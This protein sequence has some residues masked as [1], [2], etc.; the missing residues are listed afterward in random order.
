[1]DAGPARHMQGIALGRRGQ[2]AITYVGRLR[3][4]HVVH[5]FVQALDLLRQWH[6]GKADGNVRTVQC[7]QRRQPRWSDASGQRAAQLPVTPL[8]RPSLYGAPAPVQRTHAAHVQ[9]T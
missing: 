5:F 9:G 7:R 3:G 8:P 2:D 1:M 4:P 6:F